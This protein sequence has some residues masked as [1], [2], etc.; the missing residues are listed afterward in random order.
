MRF[1]KVE[2]TY[3]ALRPVRLELRVAVGAAQD[4]LAEALR[5]LV[6]GHELVAHAL[7]GPG[8]R[9]VGGVH[10]RPQRVAADVGHGDGPQDRSQGRLGV[11]GHVRVPGVDVGPAPLVVLEHDDLGVVLE[12]IGR[13]VEVQAPEVAAEGDVAVRGQA[14]LVAEE[15]DQVGEE[16]VLD[17]LEVGLAGLAQVDAR[18]LG[19]QVDGQWTCGD[20]HGPPGSAVASP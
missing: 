19:A 20:R 16:E 17:L 6:D 1:V 3:S 11:H 18:D 4:P 8:E 13:R 9:L 14:V 10:R 15:E 7:R 2:F 12:R 5:V